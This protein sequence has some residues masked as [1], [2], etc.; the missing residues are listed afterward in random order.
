MADKIPKELAKIAK[1]IAKLHELAGDCEGIQ[2][3]LEWHPYCF[4][5]S[6]GNFIVF[7][8]QEDCYSKL[9]AEYCLK[10][11]RAQVAQFNAL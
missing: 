4:S 1:V 2:P 11:L 6:I 9:S 10:N 3:T 7:N 5:I 8:D